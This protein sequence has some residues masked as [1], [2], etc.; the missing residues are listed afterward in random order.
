MSSNIDGLTYEQPTAN[1]FYGT[2]K[3][4]LRWN[5]ISLCAPQRD[6]INCHYCYKAVSFCSSKSS[7]QMLTKIWNRVY[8]KRGFMILYTLSRDSNDYWWQSYFL[9]IKK[10]PLKRVSR[11]NSRRGGS[12]FIRLFPS[13]F[14]RFQLY[15]EPTTC[16]L[17]I[18]YHTFVSIRLPII[19]R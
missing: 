8:H 17:T 15:L 2:K 4:K 10:R 9:L 13:L 18:K 7:Y 11:F 16:K 19:G 14:R 3:S 1:V 12:N 5:P 6:R